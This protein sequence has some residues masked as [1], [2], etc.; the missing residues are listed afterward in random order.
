MKSIT[1]AK[2]DKK[3]PRQEQRI[4]VLALNEKSN[5]FSFVLKLYIIAKR[6]VLRI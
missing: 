4:E 3:E 5:F 2:A 6:K 1:E